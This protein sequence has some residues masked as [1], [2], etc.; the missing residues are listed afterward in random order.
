[1][2]KR[3]CCPYYGKVD[4]RIKELVRQLVAEGRLDEASQLCRDRREAIRR[5]RARYLRSV[6]GV[7]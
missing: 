4:N 3:T 2:L 6:G 5:K 7:A 1:M